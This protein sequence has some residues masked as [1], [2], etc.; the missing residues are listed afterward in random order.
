MTDQ[1]KL[2]EGASAQALVSL[3]DLLASVLETEG[4]TTREELGA[5]IAGMAATGRANLNPYSPTAAMCLTQFRILDHAAER[6]LRTPK[7]SP[8]EPAGRPQ[9]RVVDGGA[10]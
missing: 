3:F 4:V 1:E 7:E 6:L 10:A 5:R 8:P 2:I 9:L